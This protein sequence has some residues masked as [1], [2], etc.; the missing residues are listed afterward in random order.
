MMTPLHWEYPMF[1]VITALYV[2]ILSAVV[3][4]FTGVRIRATLKRR[5][6]VEI[7]LRGNTSR[8]SNNATMRK[9]AGR[10]HAVGSRRTLKIITF[11][12]VAYFACW[13]PYAVT[14]LTQILV[15]SFNPPSGVQF[16]VMWLANANSAVNVFIYSATNK[17]FRRKCVLL[18]SRL[19]CS[20]FSSLNVSRYPTQNRPGYDSAIS[21]SN[22]S[23]TINVTPV[24]T[25]CRLLGR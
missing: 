16:A 9:T 1:C 8:A 17:Q 10:Y 11:T 3:L 12:G 23:A 25:T 5:Q 22:L 19:C 21:A 24:I 18:V 6:D 20:R 7:R 2:P 15:G 13:G 14:T 4:I